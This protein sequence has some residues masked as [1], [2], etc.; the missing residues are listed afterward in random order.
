MKAAAEAFLQILV[1]STKMKAAGLGLYMLRLG[2]VSA[3]REQMSAGFRGPENAWKT[4]EGGETVR[5]AA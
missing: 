2:T 1:G 5:K 3:R 4:E